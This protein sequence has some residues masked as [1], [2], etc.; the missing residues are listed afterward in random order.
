MRTVKVENLR[1]GDTIRE[2]GR[3]IVVKSI[4]RCGDKGVGKFHVN[5]TLCYE[6]HAEVTLSR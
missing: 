3:T 1:I 4:T 2:G 6:R 5:D